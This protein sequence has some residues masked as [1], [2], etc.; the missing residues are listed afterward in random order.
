MQTE[1]YCRS[2]FLGRGIN[3]PTPLEKNLRPTDTHNKYGNSWLLAYN[4]I[5][6]QTAWKA[7]QGRLYV[8]FFNL[9]SPKQKVEINY[10]S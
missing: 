6:W 2:I 8:F 5:V 3:F 1:R 10:F 7:S 9:G 4:P